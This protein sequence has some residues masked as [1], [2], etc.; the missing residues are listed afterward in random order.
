MSNDDI[1]SD[2]PGFYFDKSKKKYFRITAEND[3][4][5]FRK[6]NA[7]REYRQRQDELRRENSIPVHRK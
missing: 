3:K 4:Y 7:R 6:Q 1:E 5:K 2:L